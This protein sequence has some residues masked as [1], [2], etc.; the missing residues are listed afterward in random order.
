[1]KCFLNDW[2]HMD[3]ALIDFIRESDRGV[4]LSSIH[5]TSPNFEDTKDFFTESQKTHQIPKVV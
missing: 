2:K 3:E 1:M 4:M 5:V